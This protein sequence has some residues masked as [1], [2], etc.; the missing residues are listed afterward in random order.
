M[1]GR[2]RRHRNGLG[3]GG[4]GGGARGALAPEEAVIGANSD[5]LAEVAVG[6]T[7]EQDPTWFQA[8]VEEG[9]VAVDTDANI[10]D[11]EKVYDPTGL[12][13]EV[14]D[15]HVERL[16]AGVGIKLGSRTKDLEQ[17]EAHFEAHRAR[18][19]DVSAQTNVPAALIAALHWREST[20]SFDHY[21]HQGDPIGKVS[22]NVPKG[23][24]FHDWET[25]AVDALQDK[26]A[27]R[28]R[29]GVTAETTDAAAIATY[30]EF[31]NGLGYHN[32]ER[33][34]PYVYAGTDE[35]SS[36]KYVA[37]GDYDSKHVDGQL[38]VLAMVGAVGGLDREL[39]PPTPEEAWRK[40]VDGTLT[41]REGGE[42]PAVEA[43]QQKLLA[44]GYIVG[45]DG[46][47]GAGTRAQVEAFQRAEGLTPVDGVVGKGT[48]ARLE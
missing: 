34:S 23:I 16:A 46:D 26:A 45:V 1:G 6:P 17:F 2:S 48:A 40:V 42:G 29:V 9:G 22:V 43:L 41:L 10:R 30:A 4:L 21:L 20:G 25:A 24:L 32:K 8:M 28:D 18:Y 31:Y 38:G 15:A 35:Y 27:V 47:F 44:L 3:G 19:D 12:Y 5:N 39:A 37:D 36:G 11:D 14:F 7:E 13:G 33:P